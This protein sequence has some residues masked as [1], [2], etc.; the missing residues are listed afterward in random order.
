MKWKKVREELLN[1]PTVKELYDELEPEFSVARQ[2]IALRKTTGL[3]QREFSKK[4]GIQQ[5]QL[6]RIE[7]AKQAPKLDTLAKLAATADCSVEV[8]FV[9]KDDNNKEIIAFKVS[10]ESLPKKP[11]SRSSNSQTNTELV[12]SKEKSRSKNS[13]KSARKT[14]TTSN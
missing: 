14:L 7:S 6:A 3:N 12:N 1:E 8:R 11:H 9:P 4:A 10:E 2:L 13:K 5:P